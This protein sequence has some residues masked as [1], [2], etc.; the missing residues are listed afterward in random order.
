[1]IEGID[2]NKNNF[3][4]DEK[5]VNRPE[6]KKDLFKF[7]YKKDSGFLR[8]R[9]SAF[10]HEN[11]NEVYFKCLHYVID[12]DMDWGNVEENVINKPTEFIIKTLKGG[13]F[14][15]KNFQWL[16]SY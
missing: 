16:V 5:L 6:D 11:E 15:L 8:S 12:F 10:P 9:T 7:F 4:R 2:I 13:G 14:F 3:Y 1:M